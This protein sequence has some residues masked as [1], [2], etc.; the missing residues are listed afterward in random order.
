VITI[1]TSAEIDA[2][3]QA[4]RIVGEILKQLPEKIRPGITTQSLDQWAE[5]FIRSKGALPAFKGYQGFPATLCTSINEQVV[6]GIPGPR[7][8][9]DGDLLSVDVGVKLDGW[10]GDGAWSFPVG[11]VDPE[12]E[13][14]MKVTR[15]SLELGV[16][17]A[18]PGNRLSAIGH[19]IQTHVEAAGFSV[20]RDF[21]GHGIG[22]QLHE[23]P[24]VPNYGEP[25]QGVRLRAG[26]VLAIEP[27]VNAGGFG[28]RIL[29]DDWTVVT[30]DGTRSAHFEYTVALTDEHAEVIT[31]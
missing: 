4:G 24:Q 15:E 6:H 18:K 16:A 11:K 21:V 5:K 31:R 10:Y 26:M 25:D 1:K 19:A 14:L 20:V 13:R 8:L 9:K 17:Q 28:V 30:R 27:M 12:S 7:V 23:E 22:R 3:R 29:N 2:M